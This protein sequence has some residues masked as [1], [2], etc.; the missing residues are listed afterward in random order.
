MR[1]QGIDADKSQN[2]SVN[3]LYPHHPR[4]DRLA[5][6]ENTDKKSRGARGT[7]YASAGADS[8]SSHPIT[9]N[10]VTVFFESHEEKLPNFPRYYYLFEII[11]VGWSLCSTGGKRPETSLRENTKQTKN[12]ETNENL[13]IFS[14]VSL[15]LSQPFQ[16][17][18][19][20]RLN[21]SCPVERMAPLLA[22]QHAQLHLAQPFAASLASLKSLV[23][24]DHQ[25]LGSLVGHRP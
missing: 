18:P 9:A 19:F 20:T 10:F 7:F 4:S 16:V 14:F 5:L 25:N 23:I 3:Q 11:L 21:E 1:S 13:G 24:I 6:L 17:R 12:D 2:I 22:L 15:F 8:A